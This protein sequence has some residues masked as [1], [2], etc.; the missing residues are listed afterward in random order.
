MM[1]S[2]INTVRDIHALV[3]NIRCMMACSEK[4]MEK[5]DNE[6]LLVPSNH[7]L[8]VHFKDYFSA[9]A[10]DLEKQRIHQ[11]QMAMACFTQQLDRVK[12]LSKHPIDPSLCGTMVSYQMPKK[13]R[14]QKDYLSILSFAAYEGNEELVQLLGKLQPYKKDSL[15]K[16]RLLS[17]FLFA[18]ASSIK[19]TPTIIQRLIEAGENV[20]QSVTRLSPL[21]AKITALHVAC[22]LGLHKTVRILV[23]NLA[24]TNLQGIV[25]CAT[26]GKTLETLRAAEKIRDQAFNQQYKKLAS[27]ET[28]NE[29]GHPS[30]GTNKDT[31][32]S[33]KS[34]LK[35]ALVDNLIKELGTFLPMMSLSLVRIIESYK[36]PKQQDQMLR[37]LILKECFSI[38]NASK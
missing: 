31:D 19:N 21:D 12:E 15:R 26:Q 24:D 2:C 33:I 8:A 5:P 29:L 16:Q 4:A 35:A 28:I 32:K 37:C 20:N 11:K 25:E 10:T 14:E 7:R 36:D 17:P 6:D 13:D 38:H 3:D 22:L 30:Y 1:P 9:P 18:C 27:K 23:F 34:I